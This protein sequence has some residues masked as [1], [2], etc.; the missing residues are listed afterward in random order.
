V[1]AVYFYEIFCPELSN[2]SC[3]RGDDVAPVVS[4]IVRDYYVDPVIL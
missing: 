4:R 3:F 1:L 2:F